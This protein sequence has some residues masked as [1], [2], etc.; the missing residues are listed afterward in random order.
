MVWFRRKEKNITTPTE[1]KK[2]A[3]EGAWYKTTAGVIIETEELKNN[4]YVSP[5]DGF[6]VRIGSKEYYEILFDDNKFIEINEN[7]VSKDPL[8]FS[9]TKK[10][11][12][13][14]KD[15]YEK[16]N[17]KDA[18]RTCYGKINNIDTM[19]CVMDFSF[20]GG[21]MGSVLGEKISRAVDFSIENKLPFIIICK[22]GGARMQE[23]AISLMQLAKVQI[24]L[25]HLSDVGLPYI[26]V[27]TDPTFGGVSA[28]FGTVGDLVIAEPNSLIGFAGPRVIKETIGKD[29]PE[30]FQSSEFLLEKGF[31][32]FI[33]PRFELKNKLS[34]S[35]K[36]LTKTNI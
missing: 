24:K 23:A 17:L 30:G 32:D 28:S 2:D 1:S 12:D 11:I 27:L 7:V 22:S 13:R 29:L 26:S 5:S 20:I 19:V 33:V 31:I 34:D 14:L 35:I 15:A 3:P 6:H 21:S 18:I 10:Y 25:G 36:I 16:T 4:C 8:N 9:D